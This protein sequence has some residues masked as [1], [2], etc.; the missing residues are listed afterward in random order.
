MGL[1]KVYELGSF[2]ACVEMFFWQH[3][4]GRNT[5]FIACKN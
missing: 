5:T 3:E 2:Y 4:C 1:A